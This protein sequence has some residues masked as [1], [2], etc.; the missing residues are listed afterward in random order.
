MFLKEFFPLAI[1][2]KHKLDAYLPTDIIG[3]LNRKDI[4]LSNLL[5]S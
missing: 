4:N 1:A 5:R 2:H 3:I